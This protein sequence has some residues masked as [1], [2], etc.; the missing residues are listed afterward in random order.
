M[1]DG[2]GSQRNRSVA[3][4]SARRQR[5]SVRNLFGSLRRGESNLAARSS[6]AA[7]FGETK[8]GLN[9]RPVLVDHELNAEL[10]AGFFPRFGQKDYVAVQPRV[11]SFQQ[12]HHHQPGGSVV[13]IVNRA[14]TINIPAFTRSRERRV[15]PFRQINFDDVRVPHNQHRAFLPLPRKRATRFGRFGSSAKIL[16][17]IPSR[18]R[19]DFRY[20]TTTPSLPGG[21]LVSRRRIAWKWRMVSSS[22]FDQSGCGD[23]FAAAG[24]SRTSRANSVKRANVMRC[25]PIKFGF[26]R[27]RRVM[28]GGI[29]TCRRRFRPEWIPP[30]SAPG[31]GG[32]RP[33]PERLACRGSRG[34]FRRSVVALQR[35]PTESRFRSIDS[36]I[37]SLYA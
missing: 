30:A 11:H 23:C 25:P 6:H 7:A 17:S 21:L 33:R 2:V 27:L 20:S 4:R 5:N 1:N 37:G 8:L 28:T 19:T 3:S 14:S 36:A 24:L 18:S 13:F 34:R 26:L 9:F 16:V 35:A 31:Y 32:N 10:S 12:Q 15:S 29:V 22:I